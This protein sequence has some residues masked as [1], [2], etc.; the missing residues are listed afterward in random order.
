MTSFTITDTET[1][2]SLTLNPIL[3][4]T[5][6]E[7][8]RQ[9]FLTC[10]A[11]GKNI[12]I[13]AGTV[14]RISTPCLQVFLAMKNKT[15]LHHIDFLISAMPESFKKALKD[16]GLDDQFTLLEQKA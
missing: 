12:K 15:A 9:A 3:D 10:L 13:V 6:A 8:L 1:E 7:D 11:S 14:E 4:L 5:T 16:I 2:I